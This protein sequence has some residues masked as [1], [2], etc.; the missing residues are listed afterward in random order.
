[1]LYRFVVDVFVLVVWFFYLWSFLCLFFVKIKI[2]SIGVISNICIYKVDIIDYV[3]IYIVFNV[4][5]NEDLILVF[6]KNFNYLDILLV[7]CLLFYNYFV[8]S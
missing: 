5:N 1:M 6:Y 3:K 4:D 8:M 7:I 2:Y